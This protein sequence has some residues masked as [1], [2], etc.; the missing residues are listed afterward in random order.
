MKGGKPLRKM[1]EDGV[2]ELPD[3]AGGVME[4]KKEN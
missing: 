4:E 3:V 1:W 2:Y